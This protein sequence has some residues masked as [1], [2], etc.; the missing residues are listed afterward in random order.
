[1]YVLQVLACLVG[2]SGPVDCNW[3]QANIPFEQA[4]CA[5]VAETMKAIEAHGIQLHVFETRC[6]KSE[7]A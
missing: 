7:E 6:V 3:Y 1:L 5:Q 2:A 4:Q